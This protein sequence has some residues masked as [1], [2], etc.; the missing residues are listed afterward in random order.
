MHTTFEGLTVH[1]HT[2]PHTTHTPGN[3]GL[4]TETT[5]GVIRDVVESDLLPAFD[6]SLLVGSTVTAGGSGGCSM[7]GK[8]PSRLSEDVCSSITV[9]GVGCVCVCVVWCE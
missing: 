3:T 7:I 6:W 9:C 4:E 8:A 5:S 1:T 2:H